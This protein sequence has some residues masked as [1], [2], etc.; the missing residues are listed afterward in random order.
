M[1]PGRWQQVEALF[2]DALTRR[3]AERDGWLAQACGGDAALEA[4]VRSLLARE[5]ASDDFLKVPALTPASGGVPPAA[6][7]VT[8][9]DRVAQYR[10][11][12]RLGEG[13]MGV[14][15]E[16]FDERL[17]RPV[18]LKLLRPDGADPNAVARLIREARVAARVVHP[19]ICQ[20]YDLGDAVERPFIAME[21]VAGESLADRL[22]RG[23]LPAIDAIRT[24]A[25]VL[26]A[27]TVLH[28]HG[29]V[30]R[31]LKP[32]NIFLSPSG[33]KLLDFGLARRLQPP[34]DV[35][36]QP[37]T[38]A[39]MFVGTPQYASPEQLSGAVVDE[40][41]DLFSAAVVAFEMLAGR[42]PFTGATLA[43]L[44]HAV[45]YEAPPVLTGSAAVAAADR[46]LHRALA[47]SPAERHPTAAACATEL[48]AALAMVDSGQ[49]VEA[50]PILRLAVLPFR[51][52]KPDAETAYLGP[53]LADA[54]ASSLAGLESLVIRSTLKSARY[55]LPPLD[56]DR[57][58]A[59]LA[60][61]VVLTGTL[62]PA[63]GRIRVSAELVAAPAGDVWWAHVTEVAPDAVL[64]L[65]DDLARR[66]MAAL[67]LSTRDRGTPRAHA[68]SEKAFELY[69]R[70]MQLR[71][72]AGAWR[73]AHAFFVQSLERDPGFAAAWAERGRLERVL[74]KFEEPSLLAVAEVSLGRALSL[75]PDNG[76]TQYYQ[77]Q[78]EI[79][80]G[81]VGD[82][83]ARL[84]DR[85]WQR[86]AEPHVFAAL[87]HACRYCGLLDASVAAHHAAIRLDPT[88]ATS[89]LHTY[90]HQG[91]FEQALAELHRSSDPLE[92][93]LLGAMGRHEEA[94]A[95]A[96]RE[97][98]RYSAIHLL[99]AFAAAVRA[100]LQ[101]N[102]DEAVA[103]MR[104]FE[105]RAYHDG[106][107]LFYVAE[108]YALVGHA[109][110]AFAMMDRAVAG[111]FLC[112]A[113]YE[114]SVYL[115]P[116]R[117]LEA[118]PPLRARVGAAQAA[119]WRVF[120]EHRGPALLG[121]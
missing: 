2:H 27:L 119:L 74:G 56:L 17:Q 12:R 70:G 108:M 32:S 93:R 98:T 69:L 38:A 5:P 96:L 73:Q 20:V 87:V 86:R 102:T 68:G 88:V 115:A 75:D 19:L 37:L 82:S 90:Y 33:V 66:V 112:A 84:L 15:Y 60:V 65:H 107:M 72:E 81:R 62:L 40:R 58:A 80:L 11:L 111:G 51:Q 100:G 89:I 28:G 83:L 8:A 99:R 105:G 109:D 6:A 30:H 43:A 13:G 26:D 76:A 49:A 14:V 57:M 55:A 47:K 4:E 101:G 63:K 71:A 117:T 95:A 116:L 18:A 104:P 120:D 78:L 7:T 46:V 41:S 64:E 77:A 61:D 54:L 114:R 59:E 48:R 16:A 22:A 34:A 10:I 97:E 23:P 91:A 24:A 106:E 31:D 25:V 3:G 53:S 21:L 50:R 39:G 92:G 79:D 121:L 103:V 9:V 85:G 1:D 44:A 110:R 118:W 29:I 35:T 42:P 52:L 36:G 94:I 45:L 113:A 67:P